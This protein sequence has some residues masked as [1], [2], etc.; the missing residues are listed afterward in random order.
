MAIILLGVAAGCYALAGI[1]YARHISKV[2][3]V[4]P[5]TPTPA[6]ERCDGHDYVP[7]KTP[8]VFA[9]HFASIA[10]VGPILGPVIA[11]I[12]GWVPAWLWIVLGGIF[13]GAVHD[14]AAIY[15]SLR[16][17]GRSIAEITRTTLGRMG[18]LLMVGFTIMMLVLVNATFLNAAAVAL[19]SVVSLDQLGIDPAEGQGMFRIV[20]GGTKAQVGGIASMSVVIIT[21]FS[22]LIGF[23]HYKK[24]W[25]IVYCS[26]IAVAVCA[27][28]VMAGILQPIIVK[29]IIWKIILS[30][31]VL[32]AAGMPVWVL[33]QPRDF[34]NVHFLYAGLLML[35]VGIFSS[36]VNGVEIK[37]PATNVS[38]GV[39]TL[40][41]IWPGIFITIA[42]GAI[43]GF[44]AICGTGTTSKQLANMAAARKVG[45]YGMLLE[46]FLACAVVGALIIGLDFDSYKEMVFPKVD[47]TLAGNPILAFALAMG[48]ILNMGI[49]LPIA[50]GTIFG[51][52]LL[53]GF[54]VTSIDTAIRLN[55]YLFEEL[56][57]IFWKKPPGFMQVHWFNAAISVGL[58]FLLAYNNTVA[59]IWA[60]FGTA[61]QLLASL[62]LLV[63]SFWLLSKGKTVWYTLGPAI[64][65]TIT[66]VTMLIYLLVNKY[67]P[68]KNVSLMV[69]DIMLLGFA[70]A[71]V[72][73][74][75]G[76]AL[77]FRKAR[78]RVRS[79]QPVISGAQPQTA[80]E[81]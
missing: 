49:A 17:G 29:P 28:S 39:Q 35:F 15:V 74:M 54:L 66:T 50:F 65:M 62:T 56:W 2:M 78:V 36:S 64:F 59:G 40:G 77:S 34:V 80:L 12:Y 76:V 32:V 1:F 16:E 79:Y 31:Y 13:F 73:K 23:L 5:E 71:L 67:V 6:V 46:S 58:M 60:I 10:A 55:R 33:L 26:L 61:N 81:D 43:S 38:E 63:V 7:T 11:L 42:C 48:H 18:F 44:H 3:G 41:L 21:A 4:N 22:P 57:H 45:Y 68:Q 51:M 14:F 37:F 20:E 52:L 9:H 69:A 8:V 27:L 24:R 75:M 70:I 30:V 72:V 47:A 25:R 53:E 19:T